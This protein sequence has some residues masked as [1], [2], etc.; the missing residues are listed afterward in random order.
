LN[1]TDEY[2]ANLIHPGHA[3]TQYDMN[4]EAAQEAAKAASEM[5]EVISAISK[6]LSAE[7]KLEFDQAHKA[8]E[9]YRSGMANFE[10][11]EFAGGTIR[12]TI[13]QGALARLTRAR[14]EGLRSVLRQM[15]TFYGD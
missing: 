15:E 1:A 8:W 13:F 9:T 2:V 12:P 6:F 7:R 10:A 4:V 14:T 11:N 3:L 5:D